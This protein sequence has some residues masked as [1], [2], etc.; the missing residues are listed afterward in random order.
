MFRPFLAIVRANN[1]H[2]SAG[3]EDFALVIPVQVRCISTVLSLENTKILL[4]VLCVGWCY[5]LI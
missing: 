3:S 2:S 1:I 5:L 4:T